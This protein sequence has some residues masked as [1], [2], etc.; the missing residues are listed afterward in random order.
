MPTLGVFPSA[1]FSPIAPHRPSSPACHPCLSVFVR[2][3]VRLFC[4][5]ARRAQTLFRL[6]SPCSLL[7]A[8][9]SPPPAP[10]VPSTGLAPVCLRLASPHRPA[11]PPCHPFGALRSPHRPH[12][13][14]PHPLAHLSFPKNACVPFASL[15]PL[16]LKGCSGCSAPP[17]PPSRPIHRPCA[18]VLKAA[19]RPIAPALPPCHPFG[20]F[21]EP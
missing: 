4:S 16:A 5:C 14:P 20:A 7:H 15:A 1:P 13:A 17:L 21:P 10:A 9:C 19:L 11:P 3:A 2:V 18:G 8:P 12:T 6:F